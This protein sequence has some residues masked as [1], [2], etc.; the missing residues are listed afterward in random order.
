M[1]ALDPGFGLGLPSRSL[2]TA[3]LAAVGSGT[4][5]SAYTQAGPGPG[6][7]V[8]AAGSSWR[9]QV[10]Q[11]QS[12]GLDTYTI[13]GGYSGRE[14]AQVLYQLEGDTASTDYRSWQEPVL[15]TGWFAP[16]DGWG[17][18]STYDAFTA[19]VIAETGVIVIVAVDTGT[20]DAQ[21]WSF[22]PRTGTF[23]TLYDWDAGG[24]DGLTLPVGLCYD[25]ER[26]KLLLWSGYNANGARQQT[27]Y[28]SLDGGT[29]WT[30]YSRGYAEGS[31]G[32]PGGGAGTFPTTGSFYPVPGDDL[33]WLMIANEDLSDRTSGSAVNGIHLASSDGGIRWDVV[34]DANLDNH[35]GV[36]LKGPAGFAF[37]SVSA[38]S[39]HLRCHLAAHA[40]AAF[41][42][43]IVIDNS[44]AYSGVWACADADGT[45]YAVARGAVS[46]AT[47]GAFHAFRSTDGGLT[48]SAY[49][50]GVLST[51]S[52]TRTLDPRC[53]VASQ[54]KLF[55]IG[56][57]VGSTN[58]DGTVQVVALGGW[59]QVAHGSGTTNVV[60][61]PLHRFG[62]GAVDALASHG[63]T[64]AYLPIAQPDN[65][66]W[67][68]GGTTGTPDLTDAIPGLHTTVTAGQSLTYVTNGDTALY[69]A[70]DVELKLH[71]TGNVSLATLGTAGGGVFVSLVLSGASYFYA[72]RLD[73]GTDG[74]QIVDTNIAGSPTIRGTSPLFN[75]STN[76]FRV[77]LHLTKGTIT[78]W[79]SQ[80]GGVTWSRWANGST[81]TDSPAFAVSADAISFGV[82]G[83]QVGNAHWRL[84]GAGAGVDWQYSL[85]QIAAVGDSPAS[86]PLGH[87][88]GKS[89]PPPSTPYPV[90]EGTAAGESLTLLSATGG[91]TSQGEVTGLPVAY[92]HGV[93]NIDPIVSPSPRRTWRA[94]DNTAVRFVWDQ[95]ANQE[96]WNGGAV[97]LVV[98]GTPR[99]WVLEEDD[100]STGWSALGT[101]DLAEG[102]G[103]GWTRVGRYVIP[104]TATIDRRYGENELRGGTYDLDGKCRRILGNSGG[105]YT[106]SVVVQQVRIELDGID[107]TESATGTAGVLCAPGGVLVAQR[108]SETP[109]RYL[110]ARAAASQPCVGGVY[111][112]GCV[113]PLRVVGLSDPE[114]TW[115]ATTGLVRRFTVAADGTST[116]TELGP[117]GRVLAYSWGRSPLGEAQ[118]LARLPLR[119]Q[120][121]APS[122]PIGSNLNAPLDLPGILEQLESGA[123]PCVVLPRTPAV[124]ASTTNRRLWLLGRVSSGGVSVSGST[125]T[126]GINEFVTGPSL[127]VSELR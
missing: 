127:A 6:T 20:D 109:R 35:N 60:N 57:C 25:A 94:T 68:A 31:V 87:T 38:A 105:W 74:I 90:P 58:T 61:D 52:A 122:S 3:T 78:A 112:A 1:P 115:S 44:V 59:S 106:D 23:T 19:T 95:G 13:H 93:E 64:A 45:L 119:I 80:D 9:P 121:S 89:I 62:Y 117:A 92:T 46:A 107:G 82:L 101:L 28:Q 79:L 76:F 86:G 8:P 37:V 17:G 2:S 7:P 70:C 91:P 30:V 51:G 123:I 12:V 21:T 53:L 39:K 114:W 110:R 98:V 118:S 125:G 56:T 120:G 97:G 16:S 103:L 72:V 50:W 55:L 88:F 81:V 77:R 24:L 108:A 34:T 43:E 32:D 69:V 66:G 15:V 42:T 40:R 116:A 49:G 4:F 47:F 99:L 29:T 126:E 67:T 14:G 84:V 54:G 48:W 104:G 11:A 65:V 5:D 41:S 36:P 10:A 73:V 63:W 100:G 83:T 18:S 102:T 27:A 22:D 96:Q 124:T 111:E 75:T 33:D 71:S 85:D 113:A 26:S